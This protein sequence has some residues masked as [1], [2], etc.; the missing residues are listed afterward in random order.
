[1]ALGGAI[2]CSSLSLHITNSEFD[3][4][5]A[6]A[7]S[8]YVL[9]G[10]CYGGAVAWAPDQNAFTEGAPVGL[11]DSDT[12]KFDDVHGNEGTFVQTGAPVGGGAVNVSAGTT[13]GLQLTISHST[14]DTDRAFGSAGVVGGLA[15][16]GSVR[17]DASSAVKPGFQLHDNT[18]KNGYILGGS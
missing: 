3:E 6:G 9:D 1:E 17:L 18:Y 8:G 12:F 14:F 11:I 2:Y 15:E 7:I 16:G 5:Q 4:C 10:P 13:N